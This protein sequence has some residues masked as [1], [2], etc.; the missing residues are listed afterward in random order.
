MTQTIEQILARWDSGDAFG[1]V[2]R[3]I[4]ERTTVTD[5]GCW[6]CS[7]SK[8]TSGY[9]QISFL[10]GM[11]LV[12]RLT[13]TAAHGYVPARLQIDHLCR[14]RSCCNPAHLEAVTS[15]ENGLR[16]DTIQ[17]RNAAAT[18]CPHGHQYG[19]DNAFPSDLRRGKQRRCRTCHLQ[20]TAERKRRQRS[21]A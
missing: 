3:R 21:A 12:H 4:A 14:N 13:F 1:E 7:Y 15:R 5:A 9:A 8:D 17:A 18:H 10:S 11:E 20:K 16:G 2:L 6:E 19:P